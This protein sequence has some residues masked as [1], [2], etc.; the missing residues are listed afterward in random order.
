MLFKLPSIWKYREV[1]TLT[2]NMRLLYGNSDSK[3]EE[4][5]AF[6]DWFFRIGD[7]STG[8]SNDV[9]IQVSIPPDLLLPNSGDSLASIV[10]S[11]YP[12]ML[13]NMNDPSFFSKYSDFA[14]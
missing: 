8:E 2:T 3:I 13:Q 10:Q 7:G 5:K 9:D 11:T 1:L 12:N 14:P 4:R 6:S